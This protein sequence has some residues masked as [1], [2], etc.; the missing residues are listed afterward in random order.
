MGNNRLGLDTRPMSCVNEM[1]G[2][3]GTISKGRGHVRLVGFSQDAYA[4]GLEMLEMSNMGNVHLMG[5][6]P[7]LCIHF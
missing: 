4:A 1:S 6:H 3:D 2:K 5:V 7:F